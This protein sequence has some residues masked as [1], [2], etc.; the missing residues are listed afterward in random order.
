[1]KKKTLRNLFSLATLSCGLLLAS[2][3]G[4]Q[5]AEASPA[6]AEEVKLTV[7]H[8]DQPD[9]KLSPYTGMTRKHWI[10]AARYLLEGA[11]S[12][13]NSMDDPMKFPQQPGKSYTGRTENL[14]GLCRTT[15]LAVGL[16]KE[17]PELELHGIK[18]GDYYRHQLRNMITPDRPGYIAHRKGGAS[19]TLVE[20]GGLALSL[21]AMPEI[22]WEPLSKEEKDKLAAMMLSY[23]NG[24]TIGSNWRFFNIFI[25]SFF[26]DKGYAVNDEHLQKLLRECLDQYK[27]YGWY[28]D[29][30]AYDY[31]SMWA[32]QMY[33]MIWSHYY[34]A[35]FNPQYG[36]EF[37]ANFRDL[38][39]T[40]PYMWSRDGLMNMYGRSICYRTAAVV[41]FP[42]MGWLDDPSINYGWM[43]RISSA[44]LLQFLTNPALLKDNIPTLGFYGAFEPAIQ[45]YSCRGSVYW[46][47]KAF[48]GLLI[49][50]DN[51]FWTA[52]ENNGGWEDMK[53]NEVHNL[54]MPGS[55]TMFTNYANSG[56]SEVRAWC[57][58][59]V[60]S[61]WQLFRSGE[62]YNKLAYNTEFPWM[63]DGKNGEVS[64]NY[65]VKNDKGE[66]EVLRLYTFKGFENGIY[67]RDAVLETNEQIQF[68]LADIPLANGI[69][70]V[71][72]A[73]SPRATE[74][75]LGHYS[76]PQLEE[77]KPFE[78]KET[79]VSGHKATIVSNGAYSLALISLMGWDET[80]MEEA[81]GLHP[82]SDR[83]AYL[84]ADDELQADEA[85]KGKI[86]VTLMLWKKGNK[87]FT[88][89]ELT[90]VK[91]IQ[92]SASGNVV[93][94]TLAGGEKKYVSL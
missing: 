8:V 17:N 42:L 86:Y 90:P 78:E 29:S 10:D 82:V 63:A 15:F 33:G 93:E 85:Q 60:A 81:T 43:R 35:K 6:A 23:G 66:W 9:Y 64:Q 71:D 47:G 18:V 20:L 40:Y 48:L 16:L 87:G 56:A 54:F 34:G 13:I 3:T 73:L 70:R 72:K 12:Y 88:K 2:P 11:F 38:V 58:E 79:E 30:P 76:L 59:R 62:N 68:R 21:T 92:V 4:A 49:P 1:M 94:I 67:R 75:R 53:K 84:V 27:G 69:L 45:I 44:T 77:G 80:D 89:K 46:M 52:T 50:A 24:P 91:D 65:A 83:C 39:N 26:K 7:F 61:D 37:E 55:N 14:E 51:P 22:L 41:P 25:M 74:L 31:Y 36:E 28:N 57:H 5:A 32:F 19:Q